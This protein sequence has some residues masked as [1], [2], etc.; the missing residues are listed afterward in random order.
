M[1]LGATALQGLDSLHVPKLLGESSLGSRLKA[2]P[3]IDDSG[4]R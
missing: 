3:V 2:H 1:S 4:L